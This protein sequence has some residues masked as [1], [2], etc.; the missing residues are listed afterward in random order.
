MV[1]TIEFSFVGNPTD[2]KMAPRKDE[3]RGAV[4]R[5]KEVKTAEV[6]RSPH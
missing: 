3:E 4:R 1:P 5:F 2:K 6:L